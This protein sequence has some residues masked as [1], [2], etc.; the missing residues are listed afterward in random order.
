MYKQFSRISRLGV[1]AVLVAIFAITTSV[2]AASAVTGS[3]TLAD[4]YLLSTCTELAS[5][6][7]TTTALTK[8][9]A[10]ATDINCAGTAW[11]PLVN[12]STYFTGSLDGRNHF[13]DNLSITC[14]SLA[15]GMFKRL[16]GA[17][18]SNITFRHSV[19]TNGAFNSTGTLAGS[20]YKNGTT[21]NTVTNVSVIDGFVSS[22]GNYAGGLFGAGAGF[23]TDVSFNGTVTTT[24]SY[25]GGIAGTLMD[26]NSTEQGSITRATTVGSIS[27]NAYVGGI[28]GEAARTSLNSLYGIFNS[29]NYATITSSIL[30]STNIAYAGGIAGT[31]TSVNFDGNLNYGSVTAASSAVG[32]M[33]GM[34]FRAVTI[35]N[36]ANFGNL[37]STNAGGVGGMIGYVNSIS[38]TTTIKQSFN[39]GNI[40]SGNIASQ[41][42]GQAIGGLIGYAGST[43]IDNSY[44]RGV[45]TNQ[46][47]GNASRAGGLWGSGNSLTTIRTSYSANTFGTNVNNGFAGESTA[48]P[49]CNS[50][51]WDTTIS[52]KATSACVAT[53]KTTTQMKNV[54]TYTTL[55]TGLTSAWDF[56]NNPNSDTGVNDYWNIDPAINDGYPY[57]VGLPGQQRNT[58]P[59][60]QFRTM[61]TTSNFRTFTVYL[62]AT[63]GNIDCY[64]LSN[65]NNEDLSFTN[66][67]SAYITQDSP[68]SC[69]IVVT[70]DMTGGS[71][72]T[73][74]IGVGSKFSVSDSGTVPQATLAGTS[75]YQI[76]VTDSGS[77]TTTIP[78]TTTTAAP[79]TTAAATTTTAAPT[80]TAAAT[81]TTA[82][83]TTTAAT[84]TTS[85]SVVVNNVG[86][87]TIAPATSTTLSTIASQTYDGDAKSNVA[88][89]IVITGSSGLV[90]MG[91]GSIFSVSKNG[92]L[93]FKLRTGYIGYASG[94]FTASF[95]V[96]SKTTKWTCSIPKFV[97]GKVNP[98]LKRTANNWFPKKIYAL[99]SSCA[100]PSSLR[101]AIKTRTIT[102]SAVVRFVK[103]WPTTGKPTNA[104]TGVKIPPGVRRLTISIGS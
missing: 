78:T 42:S 59:T 37:T 24:G 77:T 89:E 62:D 56:V 13:I 76:T 10:M 74:T 52:G 103:W 1:S 66:V 28:A 8:N 58:A 65:S 67:S 18:I 99:P 38:G 40:L 27:A 95:K 69:G 32:G 101:T 84:T 29:T 16:D 25:A 11:T 48:Y 104:L 47:A 31:A 41:G 53:G 39:A 60:V 30:P 85:S 21:Q 82:A 23:W 80:T 19:V 14:T 54:A 46:T 68:S 70:A 100:M 88:E 20:S 5:I 94:E 7:S 4:P 6:A 55:A 93:I 12:G 75:S 17:T 45:I 3:G 36:S 2:P 26:Q 79:T 97:V 91:D 98:K 22:A 102:L 33:F 83:P 35:S 15:C 71:P 96:A 50:S 86:S 51:F 73:V 92:V 44:N 43:T 87:T 81:T 61:P 63:A 57:L 9:Y 90:T 49:V 34:N 72:A 64:T